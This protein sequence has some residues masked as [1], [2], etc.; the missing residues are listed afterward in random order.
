[1]NETDA[2]NALLI[3]AFETA[4]ATPHWD[5]ED[6]RVGEP[7]RRPDRGREGE[8]RGLR[9]ASRR[10]GRA[11]GSSSRVP[12]VAAALAAVHWRPWAG[13]LV[14]A[15]ALLAGLLLD[16]VSADEAD[17]HPRAPDPGDPVLE[18]R[19]LPAADL[20]R[21]AGGARPAPAAEPDAAA[22]PRADAALI[23]RLMMGVPKSLLRQDADQPLALF[24]RQWLQ[25]S[26]SLNTARALSV[27][28]HAAAA[29]AFGA[30][31]GL[32]TRG[33]AFEYLAGWESTFLSVETVGGLLQ[34]VLGPASFLTGIAAARRGAPGRDPA[35]GRQRGER[36]QLD[37][38]LRSHG[39]AGGGAAAH[40][41]G[42]LRDRCAHAA[43]PPACRSR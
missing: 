20:P 16:A 32:Y 1:M 30:L 43:W 29:F 19:R 40:R 28:H 4:P 5:E 11:N 34:A 23:A 10:A 35:A 18:P 39:A 17:Q 8:R 38:P 31:A 22:G 14:V 2:R 41:P 7:Q 36:R 21:G 13:W 15:A 24:V 27:L 42:R 37:P 25:A 9:V 3:R 6:R 33:L 26:A 12:A